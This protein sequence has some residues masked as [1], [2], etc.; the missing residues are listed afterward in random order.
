MLHF[1][2]PPVNIALPTA[3]YLSEFNSAFSSGFVDAPARPAYEGVLEQEP[4]YMTLLVFHAT[5]TLLS[6]S[7]AAGK[8]LTEKKLQDLAQI[9][10]GF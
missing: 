8:R 2:A 10:P 9:K 3:N 5:N 6:Y 4:R 7:I 1:C